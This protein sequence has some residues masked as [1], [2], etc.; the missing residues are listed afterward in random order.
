MRT[1]RPATRHIFP[2][3]PACRIWDAPSRTKGRMLHLHTT[4]GS[5]TFQAIDNPKNLM[6]SLQGAAQQNSCVMA[7]AAANKA[8]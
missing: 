3:F 5:H 8:V 6:L 1:V 4:L 2:N 7:S